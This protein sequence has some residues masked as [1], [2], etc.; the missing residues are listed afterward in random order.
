MFIVQHAVVVVVVAIFYFVRL[1]RNC[2]S[3]TP[4]RVRVGVPLLPSVGA[5][6]LLG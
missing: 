5:E 6:G 4:H 1:M 2:E 3:L